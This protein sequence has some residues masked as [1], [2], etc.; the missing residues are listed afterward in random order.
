MGSPSVFGQHYTQAYTN[1][2]FDSTLLQ[3]FAKQSKLLI[4]VKTI[5]NTP[6]LYVYIWCDFSEFL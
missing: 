2:L 6:E 3:Y 1:N 4:H 5:A